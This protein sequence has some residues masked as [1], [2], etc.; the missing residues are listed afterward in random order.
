MLVTVICGTVIGLD[1]IPVKV[2]VDIPHNLPSVA[3]TGLL[4]VVV[5]EIRELFRIIIKC[6]NPPASPESL[7]LNLVSSELC[8]AGF[9]FNLPIIADRMLTW[10]QSHCNVSQLVTKS[11]LSLDFSV[12]C[13]SNLSPIATLQKEGAI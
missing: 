5:E 9:I 10:E 3:I 4:L 1:R 7:P 2:E 6:T 11:E 8:K 12:F 13:R